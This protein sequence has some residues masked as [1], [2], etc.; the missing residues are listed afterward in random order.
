MS[1][2]QVLWAPCL[3]QEVGGATLYWHDLWL[4]SF[5]ICI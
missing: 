5:C 2:T 3:F 1:L 4:F